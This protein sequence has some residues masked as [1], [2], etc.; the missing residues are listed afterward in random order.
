[1]R[2]VEDEGEGRDGKESRQRVKTPDKALQDLMRYAARAERSSGD[3]LRLM[4]RWGIGEVDR[5]QILEKLQ[6]QHFIDDERFAEAYVREKTR[7]A[8][9]GIHK[10]RAGLR[11]KGIAP[12]LIERVTQVLSDQR[13]DNKQRLAE[14]LARKRRSLKEA[15]VYKVKDKLIRFGIS[16]GFDYEDVA[17][18]VQQILQD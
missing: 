7:L 14:L 11:M 17:D 13:P 18:V 6:R 12:A 8:G 1:M 15:D 3:A 16:R 2:A 5:R 4:R 10:I 9:W